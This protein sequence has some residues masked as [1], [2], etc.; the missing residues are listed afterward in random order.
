MEKKKGGKIK[1]FFKGLSEKLDKK[2]KEKAQ[3]SCCCKPSDKDKN[4][5]CS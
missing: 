5:C 2:M 3:S 4:T 1:N